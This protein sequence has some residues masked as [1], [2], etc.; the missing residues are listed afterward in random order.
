MAR[1][2]NSIKERDNE[3]EAEDWG[4]SDGYVYE[5]DLP[6]GMTEPEVLALL[7]P[8]DEVVLASTPRRF[9]DEPPL[10]HGERLL[11]YG[12]AGRGTLA[13][14]GAVL[15]NRE[16]RATLVYGGKGRPPDVRILPET[17]LRR[18]LRLLDELPTALLPEGRFFDPAVLIRIV[19]HIVPLGKTRALAV[20]DEF[21]RVTYAPQTADGYYYPGWIASSR[22]SLHGLMSVLF[23]LPQELKD[24][25]D[26]PLW[27]YSL[28]VVQDVPLMLT[29]GGGLGGSVSFGAIHLDFYR[30]HGVL[31]ARVL[32]PS[33]RPWEVVDILEQT[34]VWQTAEAS[35]QSTMRHLA[36]NQVLRLLC[37]VF[38]REP[39]QFGELLQDGPQLA[40][41]WRETVR[42]LESSEIHWDSR[43]HRYARRNGGYVRSEPGRPSPP[44][45][46]R[47]TLNG[48]TI[49][50]NLYRWNSQEVWVF[51]D[52]KG[53]LRQ[54]AEKAE[55][56]L[57][58]GAEGALVRVVQP[59]SGATNPQHVLASEGAILWAELIAGDK[60]SVSERF[61][62]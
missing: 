46:W 35:Q 7:G 48:L 8:P 13:T 61:R 59:T 15:I 25:E 11:R 45:R 12:T 27:N 56:R 36:M 1:V 50:L 32:R 20:I 2:V 23:S 26:Y 6:E 17:Q 10:S 40:S 41:R 3:P 57:Y 14:L 4:P 24:D 53:K 55:L 34:S 43:R 37:T 33:A 60:R 30:L 21:C 38:P 62:P 9:D 42:S 29:H 47:T 51:L 28:L 5:R 16:G 31:R 22:S 58:A 18:L 39:N 19:N 52:C 54:P 44:R 49:V